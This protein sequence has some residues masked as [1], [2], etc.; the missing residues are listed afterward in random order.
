MDAATPSSLQKKLGRCSPS[1]S[2][3]IPS[4][5]NSGGPARYWRIPGSESRI[6]FHFTAQPQ[7]LRHLQS[8]AHNRQGANST[9]PRAKRCQQSPPILRSADDDAVRQAIVDSMGIKPFVRFRN[10]WTPLHVIRFMSNDRRLSTR[11]GG[12]IY[13]ASPLLS[14]AQD[15][16]PDIPALVTGSV[17]SP[18]WRRKNRKSTKRRPNGRIP[19]THHQFH[20]TGLAEAHDQSFIDRAPRLRS[21]SV[22]Q[23]LRRRIDFGVSSTNSSSSMNS[24]AAPGS[25]E[26][27]AP[28]EPTSSVPDTR[29]L[30][31]CCP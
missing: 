31:S 2:N 12:S 13:A 17:T 26:P 30:V 16:P 5:E 25:V 11:A 24:T 9:L 10:R 28:G 21:I 22:K 19:A 20:N 7:F 1:N 14:T 29:T 6:G 18:G 27:A 23:R 8:S 15:K 4:T 3:F